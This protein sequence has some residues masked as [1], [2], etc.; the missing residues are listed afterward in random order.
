MRLPIHTSHDVGHWRKWPGL[1]ACG[2]SIPTP[3]EREGQVTCPR[4]LPLLASHFPGLRYRVQANVTLEELGVDPIAYPTYAAADE[5]A[6]RLRRYTL[7]WL[8]KF[9]K[10]IQ[11]GVVPDFGQVEASRPLSLRP[12]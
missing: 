8:R 10:P 4:C 2:L 11:I 5:V 1:T 7:R 3:L 12:A 9:G 6:R